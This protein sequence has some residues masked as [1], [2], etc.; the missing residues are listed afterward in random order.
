[1]LKTNLA[2]QH[3]VTC[4]LN[5][6]FLEWTDFQ[7]ENN[8]FVLSFDGRTKIIIPV[9]R[10][11]LL[12]RHDYQGTFY[13]N[14]EADSAEEISF[15]ELISFISDGLAQRYGTD[16]ALKVAFIDRVH[17]SK[18]NIELSLDKRI[19][20]FKNAYE[21]RLT[22]NDAEQ[23][24]FV[25]HAFHPT[26]KSRQEFSDADYDLY[27]PEMGGHF[28]LIWYWVSEDIFFQKSSRHFTDHQ[29][30]EN[31]FLEEFSEKARPKGFRPFPVHPWQENILLKNSAIQQYLKDTKM[32]KIGSSK[33]EWF[34]TSSLRTVYAE[35]SDY[36]LKF[37]LSVRLTN[38]MRLL[39][40]H[41]L[42]RGLQVHDVFKAKA[43]TKSSELRS[44]EVIHEPVYAAIKHIDGSLIDE[45][46]ILGR[47]NPFRNNE[48]AIVVATL[49]QDHPN[50]PTTL[51]QRYIQ[52]GSKKESLSLREAS[53]K[54]FQGY[55]DVALKPLISLQANQG[56]LLGSHQQNMILELKD[57]WPHR[58]YFRDCN[59]T[60]YGQAGLEL[61]AKEA[62]LEASNGN[63][64][65]QEVAS[66]LF[67]YY[68]LINST[69]NIIYSIAKNTEVS[70]EELIDVLR[71]EL[72][73]MKESGVK[74]SS[75]FDYL[76]ESKK[77]MHKG[78]FLCCFKN[79][80]ENTAKNPL[81]IYT[82][83]PNPF[84]KGTSMIKGHKEIAYSPLSMNESFKVVLNDGG[85]CRVKSASDFFLE[86][87]V[88][89]HSSALTVTCV[90]SNT[91]EKN[92]LLLVQLEYLIGLFTEVKTVTVNHKLPL[93]NNT[94]LRSEF[95]QLPAL[96]HH[97]SNYEITPEVW[98]E[99]QERPHPVRPES[100]AGYVYRRYIPQIDKTISF[101]RITPQDLD[102]FH[103]WHN[104]PRVS[105]FWELNKSKEELKE[106]IE[107]G[108]KDPHQIPMIVEIDGELTG[109]YEFYWVREDRL[110]PYYESDAFDRGFHFLI[111][112]K[113][114]LGFPITDSI[115]KS[116]LHLLFLDEARTRRVMAEPRHDNQ[117]V[118]KYAMSA[119]GWKQLKIFDFPHKRAV[120]LQNSREIFFGGN[121]L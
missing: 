37:S 67:G 82:E 88:E 89:L 64:L 100:H 49:T 106:Y 94:F 17:N 59:G 4:F 116:G 118:L 63:I 99:T 38:S 78:N 10:F 108:L 114:F 62:T 92:N 23:G 87:Q 113:K 18:K 27:S 70:E 61:F 77:L 5:A 121:A 44:F 93:L 42:D 12:G 90:S 35:S 21:K 6:L 29:W 20:E 34:P 39:L 85:F 51:V 69:F 52:E 43:F 103:E 96:W 50:L 53:L 32:I 47:H 71:K 3:S 19:S 74:D 15:D 54:W 11:S 55:F 26:P 95:F 58:S 73:S 24:L 80:N 33:R 91:E 65:D 48:E 84:F 14:V 22:F 115:L 25:G 120:L 119:T 109:Y 105:V 28:P 16:E 111:G 9:S 68:V 102:T 60:G 75:F 2:E 97:R 40:P 66:Y 36:M 1:M 76:L 81:S 7:K 31:I 107:K 13:K 72:L 41:E 8:S 104:Q 46:L 45:S 30:V 112:N 101:R 98:T 86:S 56:I 117:K 57:N 83:I 110:G 79:I